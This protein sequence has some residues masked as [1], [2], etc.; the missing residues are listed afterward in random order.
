MKNWLAG[1]LVTTAKEKL[2]HRLI[3]MDEAAPNKKCICVSEYVIHSIIFH[4]FSQIP[5][6]TTVY[7]K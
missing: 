2:C 6:L 5:T 7:T 4:D 3:V 1:Q